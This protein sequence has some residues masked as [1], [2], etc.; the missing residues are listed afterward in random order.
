MICV[1][2]NVS[3]VHA[4]VMLIATAQPMN[5]MRIMTGM[6]HVSAVIIGHL[7]NVSVIHCRI[8]I[9]KVKT[10]HVMSMEHFPCHL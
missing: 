10:F 9:G 7:Y 4:L 8:S 5:L 1:L 3:S 2:I 6:V